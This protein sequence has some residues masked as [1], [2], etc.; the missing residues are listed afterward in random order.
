MVSIPLCHVLWEHFC[1]SCICNKTETNRSKLFK[2][3]TYVT[4][5][6][7]STVICRLDFPC[8]VTYTSILLVHCLHNFLSVRPV[9]QQRRQVRS[10][11][12]QRRQVRSVDQQRRQLEVIF[13]FR[14]CIMGW[15]GV[16]W[17]KSEW[18]WQWWWNHEL[19]TIA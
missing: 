8:L 3:T 14:C 5:L 19:R 18:L 13:Y 4:D 7:V 12:Q 17:G 6:P 11:D 1:C 15:G 9:D 10:V 2:E 16:G